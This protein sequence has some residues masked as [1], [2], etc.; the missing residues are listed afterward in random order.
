MND[1]TKEE[2][3]ELLNGYELHSHNTRHN[4]PSIDLC[5]KIQSMIDNFCE[6]DWEYNQHEQGHC[7]KCG[8]IK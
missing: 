6:H 2:L 4:W 8:I 3:E 1:F 7:T 5:K